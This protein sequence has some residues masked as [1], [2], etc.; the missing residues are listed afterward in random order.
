[1]CVS[2][3]NSCPRIKL[4]TQCIMKAVPYVCHMLSNEYNNSR[5]TNGLIGQSFGLVSCSIRNLSAD[6]NNRDFP[7]VHTAPKT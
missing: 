5:N 3:R 1:M 4:I 6:F 2:Y 7:Y